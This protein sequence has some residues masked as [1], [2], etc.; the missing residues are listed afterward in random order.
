M[1]LLMGPDLTF[2]KAVRLATGWEV[3]DKSAREMKSSQQDSTEERVE[4]N[5]LQDKMPTGMAV[6]FRCS[7]KDHMQDSV[8]SFGLCDLIAGKGDVQATTATRRCA[9]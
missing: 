9:T 1:R 5:V 3:A 8:H 4:V 2:E 7:S 6:C